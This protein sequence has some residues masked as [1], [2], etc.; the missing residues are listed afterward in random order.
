MSTQ[1]QRRRRGRTAI[2]DDGDS[3]VITAPVAIEFLVVVTAFQVIEILVS[4]A[5]VYLSAMEIAGVV[6]FPMG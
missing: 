2:V 1:N 4:I 6:L 5:A 3:G